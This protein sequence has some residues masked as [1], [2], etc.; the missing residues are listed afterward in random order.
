MAIIKCRECGHQVSTTAK[1]CPSC[2]AKSFKPTS[3]LHLVF[4]ALVLGLVVKC[5]MDASDKPAPPAPV[6]K[7]PEQI[8]ADAKKEADF[9]DAA[10]KIRALKQVMK[11]PDSFELVEAVR[12]PGGTICVIYRAT[13][14]FN[15]KITE[16]K[17]ITSGAKVVDYATACHGKTGDNISSVRHAL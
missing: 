16:H 2:G 17:A 3:K 6:A 7:T 12:I 1:Q 8:Q 15:A 14:S 10:N 9:Q 5:T 11:N 13:N 4:A